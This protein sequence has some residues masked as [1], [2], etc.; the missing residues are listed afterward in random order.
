MREKR[1]LRID[2]SKFK[3]RREASQ[4]FDSSALEILHRIKKKAI[5]GCE[6]SVINRS[7][8]LSMK[9]TIK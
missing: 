7:S 1:R 9:L 6:S 8:G 2:W 3:E 5:S 4:N